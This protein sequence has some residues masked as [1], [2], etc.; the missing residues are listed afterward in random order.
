MKDKS[1]NKVH[2]NMDNLFANKE[3]VLSPS[4]QW[5]ECKIEYYVYTHTCNET[6]CHAW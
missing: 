6:N 1:C 4:K 3:S 2:E 5:S